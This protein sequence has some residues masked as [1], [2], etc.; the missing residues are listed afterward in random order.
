M[1]KL[2]RPDATAHNG[3]AGGLVAKSCPTTTAKYK[4]LYMH[5]GT[6]KFCVTCFIMTIALL[7]WSITEPQYLWGMFIQIM[8]FRLKISSWLYVSCIHSFIH[9]LNR[10]CLC[11][12]CA[13]GIALGM[14]MQLKLTMDLTTLVILIDNSP[15]R[16]WTGVEKW[17]KAR[18][19]DSFKKFFREEQK[20]GNQMKKKA[21]QICTIKRSYYCCCYYWEMGKW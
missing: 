3:G 5:L 9:V 12:S 17:K 18:V 11:T 7:W 20:V 2:F 14:D 8:L 19:D 21:K 1:C 15:M 16:G 10:K 13:P 4:Q 6:K